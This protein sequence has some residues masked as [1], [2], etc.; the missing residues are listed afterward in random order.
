MAQQSAGQIKKQIK[1][2]KQRQEQYLYYLGQLAYQVGDAG[3]LEDPQMMEAYQTL[4]DIQGQMAQWEASL[5]QLRIAKAEAK[6]PKCP[7]CGSAVGKG[8]VYCPGC[9]QSV[10]V[11][12]AAVPPAAVP[13]AA[14]PA[15]APPAAAAP[16]AVP[17]AAPAPAGNKCAGCGEPMDEDAVFCGNCGAKVAQEQASLP[18]AAAPKT[19]PPTPAPTA[20]EETPET[21]SPETEAAEEEAAPEAPPEDESPPPAGEEAK[22]EDESSGGACPGC[23]A[24]IADESALFCPDCGTKVKE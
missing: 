5:E 8:A 13:P 23:G 16:S 18:P 12:P 6:Q 15:P 14:A 10:T 11:P 17:A 24:D 9:G 7:H 2:L 21:P 20:E 1:Q 22:A 19:S 3:K 4:R